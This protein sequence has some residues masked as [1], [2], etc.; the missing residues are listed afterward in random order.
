MCS[1]ACLGRELGYL[2]FPQHLGTVPPQA[3]SLQPRRKRGLLQRRR[4]PA[5]PQGPMGRAIG[6]RGPEGL[7]GQAGEPGKPGIP[8]VPGRAGELGEAGRPGEK[9][10]ETWGRGNKDWKVSGGQL[11]SWPSAESPLRMAR[12]DPKEI[13]SECSKSS[14]TCTSPASS[15][16][17]FRSHPG[18]SSAWGT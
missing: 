1:P 17:L 6:E 12:E 5:G 4:G 9:V 8:G 7:P 14:G 16:T 15:L 18:I 3:V 2:P 13:R 11:C 10:S